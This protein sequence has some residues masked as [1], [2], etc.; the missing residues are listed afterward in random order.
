MVG[1][2]NIG[3]AYRVADPVF[4]Q[5]SPS[6]GHYDEV[7]EISRV[8]SQLDVFLTVFEHCLLDCISSQDEAQFA[9]HAKRLGTLASHTMATYILAQSLVRCAIGGSAPGTPGHTALQRV[10]ELME[11]HTIQR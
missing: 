10:A 3:S 7:A 11:Q 6:A 9:K 5:Y 8:A 2:L 1:G 4:P